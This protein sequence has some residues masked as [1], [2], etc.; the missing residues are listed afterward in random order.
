MAAEVDV[1]KRWKR[2]HDGRREKLSGSMA[3]LRRNETLGPS[4]SAAISTLSL[5]LALLSHLACLC[6]STSVAPLSLVLR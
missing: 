5:H 4:S 1:E 6:S 2:G 3:K